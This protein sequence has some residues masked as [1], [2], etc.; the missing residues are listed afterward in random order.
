MVHFDAHCDRRRLSGFQIHHGAPFRRPSKDFLIQKTI[1]IGIRGSLNDPDVWKFIKI[2]ERIVSIEEF[3]DSGWRAVMAEARKVVGEGPI[4]QFWWMVSTRFM[5]PAPEHLKWVDSRPMNPT[6][7]SQPTR[8]TAIQGDVVEVAPPFDATGRRPL[9]QASFEILCVVSESVA[10]KIRHEPRKITRSIYRF[11]LTL[12]LSRHR[13]CRRLKR[14]NHSRYNGAFPC[15]RTLLGRIAFE[16]L[17]AGT[18]WISRLPIKKWKLWP[19]WRGSFD[20]CAAWPLTATRPG[21][22]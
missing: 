19:R 22:G 12:V 5:L 15:I 16:Q 4:H 21:T 20:P 3:Y 6:N 13:S 10:S 7:D 18:E 11:C 17:F 8:I 1:Q 9:E 2:P 14:E